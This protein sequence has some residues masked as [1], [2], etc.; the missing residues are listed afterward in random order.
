MPIRLGNSLGTNSSLLSLGT[1]NL[2]TSA[3]V[4]VGDLI[5][6]FVGLGVDSSGVSLSISDSTGNDYTTD[7][8]STGLVSAGF[9]IAHSHAK[10]NLPTGSTITATYSGLVINRLIAAVNFTGLCH[11]TL[12]DK[13]ATSSGTGTSWDTGVTQPTIQTEQLVIGGSV[14]NSLTKGD[15]SVSTPQIEIHDFGNLGTAMTTSYKVVIGTGR[16][17]LSG[18]WNNTGGSENHRDGLVTYRRGTS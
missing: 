8:S 10:A 15:S 11:V 4:L 9:Y 18:V 1:I 3:D 13:M 12:M 5:V 17:N 14:M 7:L 16:Y 2:I 6:V